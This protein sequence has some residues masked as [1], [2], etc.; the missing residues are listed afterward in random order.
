MNFIVGHAQVTHHFMEKPENEFHGN[1]SEDT[2][3][4]SDG[5]LKGYYITCSSADGYLDWKHSK[6]GPFVW[7]K[8]P[9]YGWIKK[10]KHIG[11]TARTYGI[12]L[13]NKYEIHLGKSYNFAATKSGKRGYGLMIIWFALRPSEKSLEVPSVQEALNLTEE[14]K[15]DPHLTGKK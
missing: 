2:L 10:H 4:I 13:F 9:A 1:Q 14:L 6:L 8:G 5:K 15:I 7:S 12:R 3:V 11:F